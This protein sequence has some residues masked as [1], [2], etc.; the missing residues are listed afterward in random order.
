MGAEWWDYRATFDADTPDVK[1]V[2]EKHKEQI[3]PLTPDWDNIKISDR[4]G[5]FTLTPY[6]TTK[7]DVRAFY[8][9]VGRD[10]DEFMGETEEDG[11]D[12][13]SAFDSE[14]SDFLEEL[15]RG[16]GFYQIEYDG[17]KPKAVNFCGYS[18]D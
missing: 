3:L 8:Q 17:D 6:P 16:Q 2:L 14:D 11:F 13:E 10:Y 5:L 4:P 18:C 15:P 7:E 1:A 12:E 9:A